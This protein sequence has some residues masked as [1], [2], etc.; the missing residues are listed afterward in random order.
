MKRKSKPSKPAKKVAKEPVYG[1][2]LEEVSYAC[3]SC[4]RTVRA[5]KA[6]GE[7]LIIVPC[8]RCVRGEAEIEREW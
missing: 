8:E 1:N 7:S 3:P 2:G 4:G 5:F 6:P